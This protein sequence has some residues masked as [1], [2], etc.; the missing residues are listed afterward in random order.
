MFHRRPVPFGEERR[1]VSLIEYRPLQGMRV[2][3][4]EEEPLIAMEF[5][6]AL[7]AAGA[8]DV[9]LCFRLSDDICDIAEQ[10]DVAVLDLGIG[11]NSSLG[12][13]EHLSD[14]GV[15]FVIATASPPTAMAPSLRHVPL[16]QKPNTVDQL[17]ESLCRA[18]VAR[19]DNT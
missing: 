13:A 4:L 3:V 15:P 10:F 11:G 1:T 14:R 12:L 7:C 18:I 17:V 9:M 19:F 8:T 6:H 5:D 2:F 16:L